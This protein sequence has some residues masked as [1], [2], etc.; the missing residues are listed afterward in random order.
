MLLKQGSHIAPLVWFQQEWFKVDYYSSE[1]FDSVLQN[2]IQ[3]EGEVEMMLVSRN[4][5]FNDPVPK[6]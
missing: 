1:V 6:A 5:L 3:T 2:T 4:T